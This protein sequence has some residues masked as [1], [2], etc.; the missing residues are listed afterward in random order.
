MG[1]SHITFA[2]NKFL[3]LLVV[4]AI[5]G[6]LNVLFIKLKTNALA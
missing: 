1:L 6:V 5:T 4:S 3:T 2:D